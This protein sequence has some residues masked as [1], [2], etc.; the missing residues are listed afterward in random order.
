[1]ERGVDLAQLAERKFDSALLTFQ[2]IDL[3][4]AFFARQTQ[5]LAIRPVEEAF[6]F[7]KRKAEPAAGEYE[8]DA[9]AIAAAINAGGTIALRRYQ[10]FRFIEPQR[11]ERS[12]I[13]NSR[14][15]SPIVI[16]ASASP[17]LLARS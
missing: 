4:H 2:K 14:A 1:V 17:A 15:T 16:G 11:T 6:D 3:F 13:P 10:A 12:V 5:I 7:S 8:R 9:L